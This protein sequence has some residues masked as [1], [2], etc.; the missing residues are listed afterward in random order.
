MPQGVRKAAG[1]RGEVG[2]DILVKMG[3]KDVECGQSEG[4]PGGGEN[5]VC[6]KRLNI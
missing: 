3:E 4:G 6:K 1:V 2:R 5:Q